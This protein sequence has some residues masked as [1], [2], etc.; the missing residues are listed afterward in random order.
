[1]I[2]YAI[3]EAA[4]QWTMPIVLNECSKYQF[5]MNTIISRSE[6]QT[7]YFQPWSCFRQK[8]SNYTD[9]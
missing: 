4:R 1:M 3:K 9:L 5:T 8:W 7:L 2:L 6:L